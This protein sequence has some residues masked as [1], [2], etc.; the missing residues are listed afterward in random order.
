MPRRLRI[1][2]A[3]L[4]VLPP[5]PLALLEYFK[6]LSFIGCDLRSK[7]LAL[8]D[9]KPPSTSAPRTTWARH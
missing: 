9:V 6:T 8:L 3:H 2:P 1:H 4:N 7:P 5:M